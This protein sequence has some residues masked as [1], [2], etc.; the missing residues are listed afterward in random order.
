V[1][2]RSISTPRTQTQSSGISIGL[3]RSGDGHRLFFALLPG[4]EVRKR[5]SLAAESLKIQQQPLARWVAPEN[6]HVTLRFLGEETELRPEKVARAIAAA[7]KVRVPAFD[8]S[9][10]QACSFSGNRPPWVLRSSKAVDA[11]QGLWRDLG[12]ALAS[13]NVRCQD[14]LEFIPHVTVLRAADKP[15]PAIAI[16]PIIWPAR[17]FVLIHSHAGQGSRY[18]E[19]GRWALT[20]DR[21]SPS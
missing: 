9:I 11:L 2:S 21:R 3:D 4:A 14:T 6:Y 1:V 5:I 10:D 19:L 18:S 15:L 8:L 20:S 12:E 17:E 7:R 16:D 13:E